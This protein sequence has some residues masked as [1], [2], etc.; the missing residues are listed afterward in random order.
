MMTFKRH[1]AP[2]PVLFAIL[3]SVGVCGFIL[4]FFALMGLLP[5]AISNTPPA[6]RGQ[7]DF[8]ELARE[9]DECASRGDSTAESPSD[10]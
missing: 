7:A 9:P 5:T 4:C 6:G 1:G 3:F 2:N 8:L 10:S